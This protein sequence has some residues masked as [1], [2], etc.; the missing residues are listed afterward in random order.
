MEQFV[1]G[2]ELLGKGIRWRIG[3]GTQ[4]RVL[5]DPWVP[6][7]FSTSLSLSHL[8]M[9]YELVNFCRWIE[10]ETLRWYLIF[11]YWWM[12][13]SFPCQLVLQRGMIYWFDIMTPVAHIRL[14]RGIGLQWEQMKA[15]P[16]KMFN[17]FA[18][19]GIF[20]VV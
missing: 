12:F 5:E 15:P 6:R 20:F 7:P 4:I 8:M 18:N 14:D 10:N 19:G 9:I 3:K 16:L 1:L 13:C 11:F 2:R 17:R